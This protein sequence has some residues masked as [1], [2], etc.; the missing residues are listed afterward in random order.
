MNADF[1]IRVHPS[2]LIATPRCQGGPV[3]EGVGDCRAGSGAG[4]K[5]REEGI[6]PRLRSKMSVSSLRSPRDL[7]CRSWFWRRAAELEHRLLHVPPELMARQDAEVAVDV[8]NDGADRPATDLGGDLLGRGQ[9][10]ETR[11]GSV[12]G[13]GGGRL[14]RGRGS[15]PAGP[16]SLVE[17]GGAAEYPRLER[18]GEEQAAGDAREEI[19]SVATR[20][21]TAVASS[22]P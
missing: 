18:L 12:R 9:L 3:P 8:G 22:L 10:R 2:F 19:G 14:R 21:R 4:P 11:I 17:P 20:W 5:D 13:Q 15:G 1:L 6:G 16:W 7:R